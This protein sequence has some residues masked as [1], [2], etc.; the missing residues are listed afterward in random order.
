MR[1]YSLIGPSFP[2]SMARLFRRVCNTAARA[3]IHVAETQHRR[4]P[5]NPLVFGQTAVF[6]AG[7]VLLLNVLGGDGHGR[8]AENDPADVQRCITILRAHKTRWASTGL[9]LH[10]LEQLMRIAPVPPLRATAFEN[11]QGMLL[12][13][14][15]LHN[16]STTRAE[17]VD[18]SSTPFPDARALEF[19]ITDDL[20]TPPAMNTATIWSPAPDSF[21][22][23]DWEHFLNSLIEETSRGGFQWTEGNAGGI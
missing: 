4:R 16:P 3:C 9:P 20:S 15:P 1:V 19:P 18:P 17:P 14:E 22:I 10:T 11:S 12:V 21:G 23:P 6:T 8:R 2:P 5:Q 7:V 13:T